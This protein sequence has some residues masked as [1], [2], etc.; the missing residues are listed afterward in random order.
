MHPSETQV[1]SRRRSIGRLVPHLL[2]VALL[3]LPAALAAAAPPSEATI[4][5]DELTRGQRGYGLTV[6]AGSDPVRFEAEVIGVMRNVTPGMT[7]VLA[8]LSGHGLEETGVAGGMSGSPVYFD[9]RLAG[10]VAFAWPFS[11]EA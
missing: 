5:P 2:A 7:Y 3:G 10:A 9:G 11:N 4:S 6:L 8:R 1:P